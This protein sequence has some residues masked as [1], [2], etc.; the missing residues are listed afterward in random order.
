MIRLIYQFTRYIILPIGAAI[1]ITAFI[2]F[3]TEE[4]R[5]SPR[6]IRK[7]TFPSDSI[8]IDLDKP[9]MAR[10]GHIIDSVFSEL[11]A[12]G[13][14]NGC[15]LY[16]EKGRLVFKK[17][18]GY[19]NFKQKTRLTTSSSFQL[20][21]VSKMFTA[22]AIMILKEDGLLDYDD[23]VRKFIP[24]LPYSGV[25]IR[26]LLNHRSGIPDYMHFADEFW[27]QEKPMTNEDMIR[28]MKI[29]APPRFFSP[30]SG[31]DY[32]NS[33]YALLASVVERITVKPFE[34]FARENIFE[35][36]GMNHTFIYKLDPAKE[37]PAFVP[38]G[39]SGHK[40]GRSMPRVEPDFYQNGIVG[41]KGVYSSV[42]DLFKWDQALFTGQLVDEATLK[43]AFTPGSPKFSK[44]RDNYG[45]G[46]RLRAD[47]V[48]TVYHY[49]WWKGF[50]TYFIRDLYQ[51]KTIIVLTNTT[52]SL[53]SNLLFEILD[54]RRYEL[55][56]V[57]P[58]TPPPKKP[59]S[60]DHRQ[61]TND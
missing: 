20:A 23:S 10:K 8:F 27:G 61:A 43:E 21:S 12:K 29:N 4:I 26:H 19:D 50:R 42:E 38:V 18:Y 14:F 9:I 7:H 35:P 55:G 2:L 25:T 34:D 33:N 22:M 60:K 56:P 24:E 32:C 51:E 3:V 13:G 49:G 28:V 31:F 1:G 36:L 47:R 40:A 37:I 15:I 30:D 16:A 5:E 48:N 39:V 54:D 52:R 44:W 46:W 58:Y 57:C 11:Q 17:A 53:S 45:F 59:R 6:Y 41:D